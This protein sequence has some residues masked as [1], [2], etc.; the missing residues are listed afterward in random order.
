[1]IELKATVKRD[2]CA[3]SVEAWRKGYHV[4]D[5]PITFVFDQERVHFYHL[6]NDFQ[7]LK[8]EITPKLIADDTQCLACNDQ[9]LKDIEELRTMPIAPWTMTELSSL[10]GRI[11]SFYIFVV[12]DAFV[13]AR[14]EA[15]ESRQKSE[16]ILYDVDAIVRQLV[17][18]RLQDLGYD[19]AWARV[20]ALADIQN[21]FVSYRLPNREEIAKR[22]KGFIWR[23]N[24]MFYRSFSE[25]CYEQDWKNP[26]DAATTSNH[27]IKGTVAHP[28]Q[29]QGRVVIVRSADDCKNVNVGDVLVA[30][31][32]NVTWLP[33]MT[34]ASAI[35]TDEGGITCHAAIAARELQKPC[36]TGTKIATQI[37]QN[38][39]LVSVNADT[40]VVTKI[41]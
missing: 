9:F 6:Q 36:I 20:M 14:P 23:D 29:A 32:T 38:G 12:S 40:G 8:T 15:W 13:T 3:F 25:Y 2:L 31:M 35:I 33:A 21:L 28:G 27:E 11:M 1:M 10:V 34:I 18:N 41:S 4:W 5:L 37:F 16:G 39:D 26:E 30:T 19:P 17:A 22:T 24:E 7:R